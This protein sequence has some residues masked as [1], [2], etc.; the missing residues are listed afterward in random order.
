LRRSVEQIDSIETKN[1]TVHGMRTAFTTWAV[2]VKE[3]PTDVAMVTIGHKMKGSDADIVY[4]RNVKKLRKRHEMMTEWGD[5]V[6][7]L[8]PKQDKK[9]DEKIVKLVH[10]RRKS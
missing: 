3:Y 2:D 9:Q 5:Y 10:D 8:V 4:L 7:S 1:A 6:L